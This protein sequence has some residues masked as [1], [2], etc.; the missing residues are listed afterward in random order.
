[1]FHSLNFI[2]MKLFFRKMKSMKENLHHTWET[3]TTY[4]G[5]GDDGIYSS[6]KDQRTIH[7]AP[8]RTTLAPFLAKMKKNHK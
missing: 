3:Q 4:M 2:N 7:H 1:M 6:L 5:P 8:W